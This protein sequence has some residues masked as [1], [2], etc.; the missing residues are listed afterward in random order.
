MQG[1][2]R[3]KRD[4]KRRN[5]REKVVEEEVNPINYKMA[6]QAEMKRKRMI[7]QENRKE[8]INRKRF[9]L[10]IHTDSQEEIH[11]FSYPAMVIVPPKK[12]P[13]VEEWVKIEDSDI[14]V[15]RGWF[16]SWFSRS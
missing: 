16:Q 3:R 1:P 4:R 8:N 13:P 15:A 6:K 5:L 9:P 2:E 12:K 7:R 10:M 11:T 14:P